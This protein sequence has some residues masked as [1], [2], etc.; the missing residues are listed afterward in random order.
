MSP[1]RIS[2]TAQAHPLALARDDAEA[3]ATVALTLLAPQ[4]AAL[5]PLNLALV[6]DRSGSMAGKKLD[7]ARTAAA[8]V[9][10][11][12]ADADTVTVVAFDD[13]AEVIVPAC[14]AADHRGQA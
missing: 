13:D 3:L 6:I 5:R 9:L 12:L 2:L 8:R 11:R 10:Q 7:T 4:T 14:R 1:P